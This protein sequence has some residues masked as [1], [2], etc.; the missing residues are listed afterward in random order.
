MADQELETKCSKCEKDLD[1]EGN[2]KWCKA[3]RAK[4]QREYQ[5]LKKEMSETRG[6]A[7]GCSAM[8]EFIAGYFQQFG[9]VRLSGVEA[10]FMTRKAGL[11]Q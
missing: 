6:Y 9:N 3:C 11:P 2:P 10:A 5:S 8:R 1:T 4:Y 7:A